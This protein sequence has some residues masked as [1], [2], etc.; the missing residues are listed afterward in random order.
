M[1]VS[2]YIQRLRQAVGHDVLLMP[3]VSVCVRDGQGR[4][5]LQ[6]RTDLGWWNLPGGV[7]EPGETLAQAAV[8]EIREETGLDIEPF[9]VV[10]VYSDPAWTLTYPN[11]DR[12]QGVTTVFEARVVSGS[13]RPCGEES[14]QLAYFAPG[15]LPENMPAR[16]RQFVADVVSGRP[17]A[18]FR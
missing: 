15:D 2:P 3:S 10:G 13:L 17:Q 7:M 11:G 8:R 5:L 9:R 4:V 6:R 18:Y 12:V 1:A 16:Q 14:A